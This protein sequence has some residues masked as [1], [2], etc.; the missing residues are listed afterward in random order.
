MN[1]LRITF[2]DMEGVSEETLS[3]ETVGQLIDHLRDDLCRQYYMYNRLPTGQRIRF[4]AEDGKT[5]IV[6][7]DPIVVEVDE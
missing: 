1:E 4:K 2:T 3:S 7:L 5:Y 6:F